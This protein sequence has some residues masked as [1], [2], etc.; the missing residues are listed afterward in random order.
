MCT[1]L[2]N[3]MRGIRFFQVRSIFTR[4]WYEK[5]LCHANCL[6]ELFS[7]KTG[8]GHPGRAKITPVW[9]R[10]CSPARNPACH[11]HLHS[12][13]SSKIPTSHAGLSYHFRH[14]QLFSYRCADMANIW[15]SFGLYVSAPS[16]LILRL[17]KYSIDFDQL[18][19]LGGLLNLAIGMVIIFSDWLMVALGLHTNAVL[20]G[21]THL[22]I[23]DPWAIILTAIFYKKY[24]KVPV[25]LSILL[26]IL[27]R[28]LYFPLAWVF[29]RT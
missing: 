17:L 13:F 15:D 7:P 1:K 6:D 25:W 18:L 5:N 9:C 22:V 16:Y 8:D 10:I 20:L 27:T 3:V 29:I 21:I 4:R 24:F 23:A 12:F 2:Y 26:G 28:I 14:A 11:I 19:N